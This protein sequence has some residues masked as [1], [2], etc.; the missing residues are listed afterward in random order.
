MALEIDWTKAQAYRRYI[1]TRRVLE[2]K[3]ATGIN[4]VSEVMRPAVQARLDGLAAEYPD[5][6]AAY[7]NNVLPRRFAKII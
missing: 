2:G 4:M 3:W 7:E 6:P 1:M 5:F